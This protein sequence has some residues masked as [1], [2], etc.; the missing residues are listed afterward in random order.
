MTSVT[1]GSPR[2]IVPVLSSTTAFRRWASSSA[3][4]FLN[5]MPYSAPLPTPTMIEVGVASPMAQGQAMTSTAMSRSSAGT[6]PAPA[7]S[8]TTNVSSARAMTAGTNHAAT[9]STTR[10]MGALLPCACSTS[11][12]ICD[13]T[14]S[15][16]T[17]PASTVSK[18]WRLMVAPMTASPAALST[19]RLSPVIMLSS[20][21]ERPST[22]RPSTGT[23]S[24]GRT[25]NRSPGT[26][27]L[28]GTSR[29]T[30]SRTTRAV[31]GCKPIS[32]L[33][34]SLVRPL[35]RASSSLPVTMRVMMTAEVSK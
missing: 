32:F 23:F 31:F 27:S 8:Q 29:S 1:A 15:L 35:A 13:S 3:A 9:R 11:R 17:R 2:V 28:T 20:T 7:A 14:V 21:E 25:R 24:P 33:I 30:P 22:T 6:N 34:A 12:M 5:R 10:W 4:L 16:P 19:G 26:T 18:P